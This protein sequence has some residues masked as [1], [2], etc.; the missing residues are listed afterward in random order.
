M[1]ICSGT[2]FSAANIRIY[3]FFS[4]QTAK[5]APPGGGGLGGL[6]GLAN[7]VSA[8]TSALVPSIAVGLS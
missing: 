4:C 2:K 3:F 7:M 8:V 5:I 6:L 1:E